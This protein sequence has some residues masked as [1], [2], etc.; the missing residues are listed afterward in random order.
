MSDWLPELRTGYDRATLR[1]IR[2]AFVLSLLLHLA[3]LWPWLPQERHFLSLENPKHGNANGPL[4]VQLAPRPSRA[5]PPPAP[6]PSAQV[7]VQPAPKPPAPKKPAPSPRAAPRRPPAP[8][9]VALNK[10]S[11]APVA[12]PTPP[13]PPTK[14]APLDLRIPPPIAGDFSSFL[15]A[16]RL[17]RGEAMAATRPYVPPS[18]QPEEDE[19]ERHNRIVAENLGLQRTPTF[20]YDPKAGGGIFR[21]QHLNYDDAELIFFG[22]NQ[23]I[24]RNTRQTIEVER[25]DASDIRIAVI[26][27]VIAIIRE[28]E[29][30]DFVWV[31]NRLGRDV[32]LSARPADNAGLEDFLMR[33]FFLE[34]S[35]AN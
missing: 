22:W 29:S 6:P 2:L 12:P 31:S 18:P 11:S 16:R 5:T 4:I 19:N 7:Q 20:G 14:P 1:T 24:R 21:I 26:R 32:T 8:P 3:V 34:T 30:G 23:T 25:G 27:K 9:V 28:S 13:V 10:P 17:A 35:R 15:E 33:D